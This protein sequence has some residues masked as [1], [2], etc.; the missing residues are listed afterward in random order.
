MKATKSNLA[1]VFT[2]IETAAGTVDDIA[3]GILDAIRERDA[4]TL[5]E[6]NE[7]VSGAYAFNGWSQTVG[8]P[9][10]GATDTPAPQ[11]V[12]MYV[13]NVRGAYRAGFDVQAFDTM[14]GL[15]KALRDKRKDDAKPSVEVPAEMQGVHITRDSKL[16]GA[17][18]HDTAVLYQHLPEAQ[19]GKFEIQLRELVGKFAWRISGKTVTPVNTAA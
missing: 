17:L 19:R 3:K 13:S 4:K 10:E 2:Q 1:S 16:T 15:R 5:E 11:A 7:M 8:R 9:V 18:I 14:Y 12:K 6:F